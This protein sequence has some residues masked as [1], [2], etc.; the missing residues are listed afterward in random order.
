MERHDVTDGSLSCD[1]SYEV[2]PGFLS[3]RHRLL[4]VGLHQFR[5]EVLARCTGQVRSCRLDNV[6]CGKV[7]HDVVVTCNAVNVC[8]IVHNTDARFGRLFLK[9]QQHDKKLLITAA[10][11]QTPYELTMC[12]MALYTRSLPSSVSRSATTHTVTAYTSSAATQEM[13]EVKAH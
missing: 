5:N 2:F 10:F 9:K 4:I 12:L 6:R 3:V 11:C 13:P 8:W 1:R 7:H